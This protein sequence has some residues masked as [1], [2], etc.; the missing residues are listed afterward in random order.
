MQQTLEEAAE[1][2]DE[3]LHPA[4]ELS[5]VEYDDLSLFLQIEF[6][7][8]LR[9]SIDSLDT[10]I[11]TFVEPEVFISK[12]TGKAVTDKNISKQ[13]PKQFVSAKQLQLM[14]TAADSVTYASQTVFG[15]QFI[16]TIVLAASLKAMWNLMHF[17]QLVAYL[18]MLVSWPA[19]VQMMLSAVKEAITL[20]E[21]LPGPDQFIPGIDDAP[22]S[23]Q[24]QQ[25]VDKELP[26]S[27]EE[28]D[29][30][31][32]MFCLIGLVITLVLYFVLRVLALRLPFLNKVVLYLHDKLFYNAWI[33]YMIES[34]LVETHNCIFYLHITGTLSSEKTFVA[35]AITMFRIFLL[36]LIV[37]W[38]VFAFVFLY[39]QRAKLSLKNF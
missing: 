38:I 5:L 30:G 6:E 33:R 15:F 17:M 13:V 24:A 29:V 1:N 10:L 34:N 2:N 11:I 16:A 9:I 4:F 12:R 28:L 21:T 20:D 8:P 22:E 37:I 19:N 32:F 26:E 3:S 36:L 39:R 35:N 18:R 31:I 7:E 27:A 14:E 25:L 23:N